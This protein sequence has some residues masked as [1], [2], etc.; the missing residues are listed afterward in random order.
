MFE[1]DD[2]KDLSKKDALTE[3][4]AW[5]GDDDADKDLSTGILASLAEQKKPSFLL[6]CHLPFPTVF[7][8]RTKITQTQKMQEA[9]SLASIAQTVMPLMRL[10]IKR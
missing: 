10:T 8:L 2:N 7:L 5:F 4:M 1:D 9:S 3:V 6:T